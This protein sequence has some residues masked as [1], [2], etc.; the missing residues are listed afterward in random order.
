MRHLKLIVFGGLL[1]S[2][3]ALGGWGLGKRTRAAEPAPAPPAAPAASVPAAP[4]EPPPPPPPPLWSTELPI[5]LGDVP[6][7]LASIS[8]QTCNGCHW[9]AHDAWAGSAH[10]TAWD[11]GHFREAIDRVGGSTACQSCHLPLKSQHARLAV[12]YVQGDIARPELEDNPAWT[13]TLTA[14]GVTCAACHVRQGVV[15][16]TREADGPHP[17]RASEELADAKACATCHQFTWPDADRPFY[18]TYGEWAASPYAAAGVR[19]QDCHMPLKA[20]QA[21]ASR[22]AATATHG[23]A[24]DA[25]RALTVLID[26]PR[27]EI[28]RGEAITVTV[29]VLNTGG[30][31][32]VPTGS[33]FKV[34]RVTIDLLGSDGKPLVKAHSHDL[35]RTIADEP[36]WATTE[37]TR[38]PVGGEVTVTP[39]F[40]VSQRKKAQRGMLRVRVLRVVNGDVVGEPL[41]ER[42]L[43]VPVL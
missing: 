27:P 38:L 21:T 43:P 14:E 25:S 4:T 29:R 35:G 5:T 26:L 11:D 28:Q 36:P 16:S 32:T 31:H 40:T 2:G 37:D 8:A 22:F 34:Y 15:L 39:E 7:G 30:G 10:A 17:V 1:F 19:C 6:E 3:G 12:G 13:P 9:D 42:S 23:F 41:L 20:E 24:V 18:D 33:P